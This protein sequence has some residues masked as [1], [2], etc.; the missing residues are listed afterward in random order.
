VAGDGGLFLWRRS[1]RRWR[2]LANPHAGQSDVVHEIVRDRAGNLWLATMDGILVHRSTGEV[3]WHRETGG[4]RLGAVTGLAEDSGGR[5]WASSGSE[6]E[7]ALVREGD[8]WTHV[9]REQG[10]TARSVHK[11]R[12]DR[13]GRLWFLGLS[14]PGSDPDLGGS[15]AHRLENGR[16]TS[17]GV[18]DGLIHNRV[19]DFSAGPE[20]AYWFATAG[21]ISRWQE[22]RWTHWTSEHGLRVPR[23][24]AL[25]VDA[26]G[27]AWFAHQHPGVGVI[28]DDRVAYFGPEDGLLDDRVSD[29]RLDSRGWLWLAGHGGLIVWRDGVFA[30]LGKGDGLDNPRLWPVLPDG[31]TV[32][33]GS[34]GSGVRTLQLDDIQRAP[35]RIVFAP[36]AV[37]TGGAVVRW[38]A[39]ERWGQRAPEEV[40]TRYRV[41]DARWSGWSVDR[42]AVLTGLTPGRHGLQVQAKGIAGDRDSQGA[43]LGFE[44]PLPLYQRVWF[45]LP[46]GVLSLFVIV[47]AFSLVV[48]QR[49]HNAQMRLRDEE[50]RQAQKMEAVG[51]LAGGIAHDFNNL[52]MA[53]LGYAELTL[54]HVPEPGPARDHV[55]EIRKA[56][57][58]A[59]SLTRQL[60]AFSRRQVLQPVELDINAVIAELEDMLGR[61]IGDDVRLTTRLTPGLGK[62]RADVGQ[63]QQVIL[64]L[65]VNA[66]D[67][68]PDGG[69]LTLETGNVQRRPGE[70]HVMLAVSDTG[71]GMDELTRA[72][73]FEPFFTTKEVGKGTGLGLATTYGIVKQS[74]GDIFVHSIPGAGT[75]FEIILPTVDVAPSGRRDAGRRATP[76]P[77][78]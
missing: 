46:V 24:F 3:E 40:P 65:A 35:P 34:F 70:S 39:F 2:R 12:K 38:Q 27:R 52:L 71:S 23:V 6:F 63:L 76:E 66:R 26:R 68:M 8:S 17:V 5:I 56:S 10:L 64:N 49:R 43:V 53:I 20:E 61:L 30:S 50:L 72:R 31:D 69:T 48:R 36:P 25:E 45:L 13:Q 78:P 32:Y 14:A 21:G 22:G 19:Y 11:I 57:E 67:A 41:D 9:G 33:V 73:I 44:I 4:R 74:G 7:G 77:V 28:E 37:H 42:E 51:R 59:A 55:E 62:V 75:R 16:F 54:Q 15:G 47:L 58:R 60:L 29:I 18:E 1:S